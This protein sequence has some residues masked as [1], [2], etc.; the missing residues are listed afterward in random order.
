LT[1]ILAVIL[2]MILTSVLI[3]ILNSIFCIGLYYYNCE[4]PDI[5]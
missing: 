5:Y 1:A 4:Q 2:A 3:S